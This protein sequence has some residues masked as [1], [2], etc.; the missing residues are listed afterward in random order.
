MEDTRAPA[1]GND[2]ASELSGLIGDPRRERR[3][4][5]MLEAWQEKPGLGFPDIFDADAE[6]EAAYRFFGNPNLDFA[7]VLAP[8]VS[9]SVERCKHFEEVLCIQDTSTFVFT[10]DR[11]GLGYIN[12]ANRG[13]L[14]HFAMVVTR[15]SDAPPIPLGV[16]EAETWVRDEPRRSKG[17]SQNKLR[18]SGDCESH[19]WL[20]TVRKSED[21][22]SGVTSPIHVMDRE[23][24][25]YDCT[26]T[27]VKN[28]FRF[29]VRCMSNRII[30][31]D[32]PDYHLLYDALD[33]LAVRYHDTVTISRRKGSKLPDQRKAYPAREGRQAEVCVTATTVTVKRTRNS[34]KDYPPKTQINLVHVFEPCPPSNEEPVQWVLLTNEPISTDDEIRSI[35]GC[36]RQ[37]WIIEEFFKAIKTGCVFTK[38][39]LKTYS[40]LTIALAMTLP[41]AWSMLLLRT[42]ARSNDKVPAEFFVDEFRLK[43][44][45]AHAVRYKLPQAPSLRDVAYAIAGLAGHLKRNGPPG[46][47]TLRRG[48]EK[49]LILEEAWLVSTATCD[50]S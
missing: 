13:F 45:R 50:Q 16:V 34:S 33:G 15:S 6:L 27:M 12:K 4:R 39:Q 41:I 49:L 14:G 11:E 3:A 7:G 37:R 8:H 1:F 24:D 30:E 9:K 19:R 28:K 5:L 36:Y 47:Q 43:I 35:I 2:V 38:R 44:I 25:I 18:Q 10:G 32:D 17:V 42:Q 22:L 20:E 40:A 29:V 31:S 48:Y 23:G 21:K 46:W 26:S